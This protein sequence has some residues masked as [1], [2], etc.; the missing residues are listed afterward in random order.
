MTLAT[1]KQKKEWKQNQKRRARALAER[2]GRMSAARYCYETAKWYFEEDNIAGCVFWEREY[3]KATA[4][5]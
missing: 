3:R 5:I 2:A 4:K 1:K